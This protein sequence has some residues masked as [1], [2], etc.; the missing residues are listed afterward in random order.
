M[1]LEMNDG[2]HLTQS[3]WPKF[4]FKKMIEMFF[5]LFKIC[6]AVIKL[7]IC[8]LISHPVR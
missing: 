4:S 1:I 3:I 7:F 2:E 6:A 5:E 8:Y